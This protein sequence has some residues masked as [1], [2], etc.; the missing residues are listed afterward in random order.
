MQFEDYTLKQNFESIGMWTSDYQQL[1]AAVTGVFSATEERYVLSL[2]GFTEHFDNKR[3]IYGYT[4]DGKLIWIPNFK[5]P[6]ESKVNARFTVTHIEVPEFYLFE[7]D[8]NHFTGRNV[9][10]DAFDQIFQNS[11]FDF[12]VHQLSFSTNH[13]LEWMGQQPY[14]FE[15]KEKRELHLPYGMVKSE[16]YPLPNQF[17]LQLDLKQSILQKEMSIHMDGAAE[18]TLR[19]LTKQKSWFK[20]L[21]KEALS[22]VKLID[23]LGG[24]V[25][26]FTY[27]HFDISPG[28]RGSYYFHQSHVTSDYVDQEVHTTYLDLEY[29]FHKVLSNYVEK[30]KKLDLVLDDYLSE[31]YLTEFYE[32]KLLNS[33][34]N[35][36]ILHRNFIEPRELLKKDEG[37]EEAREKIIDF[38]NE[39]VPEKY[40]GRFRSQVYYQPEKSLRK[41][42][43]YLIK[44]LPDDVFDVMQI[45]APKRR[46]SRSIGSFVNRLIETRHYYTH[47]DFPENYPSGIVELDQIKR[48][49]RTLRKICLYYVYT[50]LEIS[51]EIIFKKISE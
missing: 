22:I 16:Q 10:A 37:I 43:D 6:S 8:P 19:K 26:E 15:D 49:N 45:K 44:N 32:T 11:R 9:I 20:R 5:R 30:R 12:Q 24:W 18:M 36:E 33:I 42:M 3:M 7:V 28:I 27:L 38:I 31:Y 41:R 21:R 14:H 23:F 51:E 47:G 13:L 1:D 25:N 46:K 39:E 35:L 34:R 29:S 50:E 4:E 17:I 48:V 2:F 40:Q